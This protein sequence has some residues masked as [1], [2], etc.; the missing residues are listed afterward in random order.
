M[1]YSYVVT[2]GHTCTPA[3]QLAAAAR[4]YRLPEAMISGPFDWFGIGIEQVIAAIET[5]FA[6]YFAPEQ[7]TVTGHV[8]DEFWKVMD[9]RGVESWHHFRRH[10]GE[11]RLGCSSWYHFGR[12]LGR[13]VELWERHLSDPRGSTLFVRLADPAMPDETAALARLAST[14]ERRSAGKI[15]VAALSFV[16]PPVVDHPRVRTFSVARSWPEELDVASVAWDFDYGYG[17]AWKGHDISWER[18]WRAV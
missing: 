15:L 5:K 8:Q 13:R 2:L 18:V 14:L 7:V 12:W 6:R 11:H 16:T 3:Y 17:P 10:E 9:G 4:R 1:D